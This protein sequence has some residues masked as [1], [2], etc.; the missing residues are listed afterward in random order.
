MSTLHIVLRY[1]AGLGTGKVVLWCY[2]IWYLVTLSFYFDPSPAIWLNAIGISAVIG[3]GLLLSTGV[4]RIH[5]ANA[6]HIFRLFLI[7]FCVASFSSLIKGH[8]YFLIFPPRFAEELASVGA[9]AAFAVLVAAVKRLA[10]KDRA[11]GAGRR[12][13]PA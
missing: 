8:G 13:D 3:F 11:L 12:A 5:K 10:P 4:R 6:W 1:L 9:C 2:L 7:P